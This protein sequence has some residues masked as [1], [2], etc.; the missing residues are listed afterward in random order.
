[1]ACRAVKFFGGVLVS[2]KLS[3]GNLRKQVHSTFC[4]LVVEIKNCFRGEIHMKTLFFFAKSQVL[5]QEER[6]PHKKST[7]VEEERI[8]VVFY[9]THVRQYIYQD[10]AQHHKI[11]HQS[12]K[13]EI[14]STLLATT[15]PRKNAD[16]DCCHTHHSTSHWK[17]QS[18]R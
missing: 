3:R 7:I 15:R 4:F 14:D 6:K 1:M 16:T 13:A 8:L 17:H 9:C 11:T 2:S 18:V 12:C 10:T 5:A